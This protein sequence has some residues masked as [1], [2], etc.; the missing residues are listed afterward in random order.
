MRE[1]DLLGCQILGYSACAQCPPSDPCSCVGDR[2]P[3]WMWCWAQ[4]GMGTGTWIGMPGWAAFLSGLWIPPLMPG[5]LFLPEHTGIWHFLYVYGPIHLLRLDFIYLQCGSS[6]D[7]NWENTKIQIL[8]RTWNSPRSGHK[9]LYCCSAPHHTREITHLSFLGSWFSPW[10][11]V[12][13]A[14]QNGLSLPFS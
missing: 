13:P 1:T 6:D 12:K 11:P 4:P 14:G 8:T 7:K 2:T 3:H 9:I 10:P 5:P